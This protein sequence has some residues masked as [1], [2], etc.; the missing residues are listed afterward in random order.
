MSNACCPTCRLR[1]HRAAAAQLAAC[2]RC[3][4][5]LQRLALE[6]SVGFRLFGPEDAPQ[7]LPEAIAVSM[8]IPDP[9]RER[10]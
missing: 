10:S 7:P 4:E 5:E 9:G 3:G 8:P 1:F 6:G 2:P